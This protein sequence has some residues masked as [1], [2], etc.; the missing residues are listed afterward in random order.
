[1]TAL[2]M[3]NQAPRTRPDVLARLLIL[4]QTLDALPNETRICEF[5]KEALMTVPGVCEVLMHVC[6]PML[7]PEAKLQEIREQCMR[8]GCMPS[9]SDPTARSDEAGTHFFPL[10]RKLHLFGFLVVRTADEGMLDPYIDLLSNIASAIGN[11]LD[12]RLHHTQLSKTTELLLKR[13]CE[14]RANHQRLKQQVSERELAEKV[15][16]ELSHELTRSNTELEQLAYVASHDLQEPL[17]MVASYLQLLEKKYQGQLDAD[18][19]EYIEFAVDGAKRMQSLINDLLTYSRIGVAAS[20]LRPT[21]S[22]AAVDT[23]L[24]LLRIAVA[25]SAARIEYGELPVVMGDEDQL[26]QLFQNLIANAIKFRSGPGPRIVVSAE[27]EDG[28]WR[29]SVQDNGIGIG[30]DYF[31]RIFVM[32]QRLHSRSA[33]PG[34]GI[35]LAICKKIVERH[36]GRIWVESE[37]GQGTVFKFT[38]PRAGGEH[39]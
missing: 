35:G 25:E 32:F 8:Q 34:T 39:A 10:R 14:L 13:T 24:R 21:D 30:K 27:A 28:Y 9:S 17:R 22:T 1:M 3:A 36:G 12:S 4:Q 20:P 11:V 15:L 23:A 16:A 38:L 2:E 33:Y 31:D 7:S 6:D 5:T 26:V 18:A 29:F 37:P 19:H